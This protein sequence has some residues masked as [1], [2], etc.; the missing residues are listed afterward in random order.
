[1]RKPQIL[2]LDEPTSGLDSSSAM[3]LTKC[4]RAL[5]RVSGVTVCGVIHQP[6]KYIFDLFHSLILLADGGNMVYAGPTSEAEAYFTKMSYVLP[7]G[8]GV[9]D[10]LIDVSSGRLRPVRRGGVENALAQSYYQKGP[11][12]GFG[13]RRRSAAAGNTIEKSIERSKLATRNLC[14]AWNEYF[15]GLSHNDKEQFLPPKR[16]GL[17][18]T[19]KRPGFFRQVGTQ[20]RRN[21]LIIRRNWSI[22]FIDTCLI[23]GAVALISGLEGVF[24]I[25]E[26]VDP[27]VP[28][29]ALESDDKNDLIPFFPQLFAYAMSASAAMQ[30]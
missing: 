21:L 27:L 6:R 18:T 28:Y 13:N 5:V 8:E 19:R 10:W 16:F 15:A 11:A 22:K 3:L 14:G 20:T 17:P 25:T 2:F 26:D 9:A 7:S 12:A 30:E 1:M 29:A 24:E 23:V 4:L